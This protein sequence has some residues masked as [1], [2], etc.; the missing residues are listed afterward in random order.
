MESRNKISRNG[1]REI[2]EEGLTR[3]KEDAYIMRLDFNF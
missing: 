1:G 3:I 2:L